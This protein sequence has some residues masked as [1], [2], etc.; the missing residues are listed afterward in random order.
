MLKS[1]GSSRRHGK[2]PANKSRQRHKEPAKKT[3][4]RKKRAISV[5]DSGDNK[6]SSEEEDPRPY[7]KARHA[8]KKQ[9]APEEEPEEAN[10]EHGEDIE[11]EAEETAGAENVSS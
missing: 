5:S 9:V 2:T 4:N 7:K 11:E 8:S 3:S 6:T 1:K 10:D